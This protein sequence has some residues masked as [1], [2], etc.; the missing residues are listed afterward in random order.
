MSVSRRTARAAAVALAPIRL[1]GPRGTPITGAS[2]WA[3][4]RSTRGDG[5]FRGERVPGHVV[6]AEPQVACHALAVTRVDYAL[7]AA[8][9]PGWIVR[10]QPLSL[11]DESAPEP[12]LA[13]P[14]APGRL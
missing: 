12:D 2:P 1:L 14:G 13:V 8:L 3:R 10:V 9:P 7:R 6:V 4:R 11:D 5:A